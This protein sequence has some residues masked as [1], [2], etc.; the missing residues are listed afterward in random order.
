MGTCVEFSCTCT[1]GKPTGFKKNGYFD[2]NM[3]DYWD[4]PRNINTNLD[5]FK[6]FEQYALFHSFMWCTMTYLL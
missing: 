3:D 6:I 5:S 4:N 2:I 1:G